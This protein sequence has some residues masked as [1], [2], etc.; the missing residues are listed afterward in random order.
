MT[1]ERGNRSSLRWRPAWPAHNLDQGDPRWQQLLRTR[2]PR[3]VRNHRAGEPGPCRE[4]LRLVQRGLRRGRP[5][6]AREG[7][8]RAGRGARRPVPL[9]HRRVHEDVPREGLR[10]RADDGSGPRGLG[11]PGR[12]LAGPR[13]PD[14]RARAARGN[15]GVTPPGD[16]RRRPRPREPGRGPQGNAQPPRPR[17][18]ARVDRGPAPAPRRARGYRA[19]TSRRRSGPAAGPGSGRRRSRSSRST[20]AASAT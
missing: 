14:A 7:A 5:Q 4:V 11:H 2:A 17:L 12:L 1:T 8:D 18:P 13:R 3:E 19:A 6:R 9:L 20:S 15:G 10:S 16:G